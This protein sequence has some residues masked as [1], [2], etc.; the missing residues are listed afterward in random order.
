MLS[1]YHDTI[2]T[3]SFDIFDTLRVFQELDGH[4]LR[5]RVDSIDEEGIKIELPGVKAS[6]VEVTV[7]NRTLKILG[8][9]RHGK[10][11]SYAYTLK[12]SVDDTSITAQ[13]QDG[14]LT[15]SL[16]KKPENAPRKI[17]VTS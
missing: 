13:L 1:R 15:I 7:Q 14:L 17:L 4:S 8:K 10:E 2:R 16:P 12:S 6:D 11:F 9:S 5:Q 3:P